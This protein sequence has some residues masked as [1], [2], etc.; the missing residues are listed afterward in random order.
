M[1]IDYREDEDCIRMLNI[2]RKRLQ[3]YFTMPIQTKIKYDEILM[4]IDQSFAAAYSKIGGRMKTNV[5]QTIEGI[6]EI[7]PPIS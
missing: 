2:F 3:Q 1:S 4:V 6:F 7:I 5:R